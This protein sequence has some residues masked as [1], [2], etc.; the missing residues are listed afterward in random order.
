MT[1]SVITWHSRFFHYWTMTAELASQALYTLKQVPSKVPSRSPDVTH[2]HNINS[3]TIKMDINSS[4]ID[5]NSCWFIVIEKPRGFYFISI[6][7][8]AVFISYRFDC[9]R[10]KVTNKNFRLISIDNLLIAILINIHVISLSFHC[11]DQFI[12]IHT[13]KVCESTSINS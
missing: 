6:F 10:I 13:H 3:R 5:L 7:D 12:E 11:I 2:W 8:Q 1:F 4:N 9:P